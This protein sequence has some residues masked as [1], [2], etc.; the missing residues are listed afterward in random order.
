MDHAVERLARVAL[1][2]CALTTSCVQLQWSQETVHERVDGAAVA[3]LQPGVSDLAQCL[4][5]L[6]APLYVWEYDGDGVALGFGALNDET[7]GVGVNIP[8]SESTSAS[9]DYD[10]G[11]AQTRGWVLFF[12]ESWTLVA[13]SEGRLRDLALGFRRQPPAFV[14]E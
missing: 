5:A 14:D 11:D 1:A 13:A 6:G 9:F 12:D 10:E 4:A 3:A 2:L 7:W 8:I